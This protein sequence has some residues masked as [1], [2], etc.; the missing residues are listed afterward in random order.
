MCLTALK[1]KQKTVERWLAPRSVL[2]SEPV[3]F[4]LVSWEGLA[5]ILLKVLTSSMATFKAL[6]K[7]YAL[8]SRSD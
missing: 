3:D 7:I 5:D 6:G 2:H 8:G 4:M 1:E